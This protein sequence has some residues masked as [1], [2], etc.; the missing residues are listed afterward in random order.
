MAVESAADRAMFLSVADFGVVARYLS[1]AGGETALT[2]IFD[3]AYLMIDA[4]EPG[5][6]GSSP[7][8]TCR[9]D[10]LNSLPIGR[11]DQDD[12]IVIGGI[13][14]AISDIQPDGTGMTLLIL[15]KRDNG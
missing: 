9:S 14:Y 6:S 1:S 3:A 11:A 7:V 15:E 4:G 10:D 2:G 12:R 8:F 13:E 5:V